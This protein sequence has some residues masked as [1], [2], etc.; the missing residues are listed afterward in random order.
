MYE[1]NTEKNTKNKKWD[2]KSIIPRYIS[3]LVW[4]RNNLVFPIY[5]HYRITQ[6]RKNCK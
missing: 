3:E 6:S 1:A 2:E 5:S 4:E